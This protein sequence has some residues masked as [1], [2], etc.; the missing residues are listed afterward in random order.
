MR[1]A[2][3]G[4]SGFLGS[5]LAA[6]LRAESTWFRI[7]DKNPSATF[8][9][10]FVYGDVRSQSNLAS[11][12]EGTDIDVLVNLAAE[13][14]D[15]VRPVSLYRD[16]NVQG[17]RNVC[18]AADRAGI[19]V[20][21]FTSTVAVYGFAP[22]DT[23]EDGECRPFNEYGRSKMDAEQV[24][25]EWLAADEVRRSLVIVRPTVVFGPNNRGNVY[26]LLRQIAGRRFV[27]VG[28]GLNRKSL[29]YVENISAFVLHSTSFGP[30]LH[31]Y[32]YV[33]KPDL[34]MNELVAIANRVLGRPA[35]RRAY[36]P[37]L[38][39][40]TGG[41]LVDL[42][43]KVTGRNYP[44]SSIR[45]KKFC[46]TTQFAAPKLEPS[47]FVPPVDLRDAIE[48]TIRYEFLEDHPDQNLFETE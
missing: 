6:R 17:A 11:A 7:I 42:L 37:Y 33:D 27:M 20:I 8:P 44:V 23:D 26:N 39:G 19:R 1:V 12:L 24:Y 45:V 40:Y 38:I 46:S 22:P 47:G 41:L 30:G 36:C 48:Q 35:R 28:R 3:V 9:D 25:R 43:S 16:V 10:D 29:A 14:T 15:N 21:V 13:H 18:R 32:N 4:G 5:S 31:I 2:V 34:S